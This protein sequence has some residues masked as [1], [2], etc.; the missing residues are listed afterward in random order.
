MAASNNVRK[1]KL[2]T[3]VKC[4]EEY[5]LYLYILIHDGNKTLRSYLSAEP[6]TL[7]E[8]TSNGNPHGNGSVPGKRQP[9]SEKLVI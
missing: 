6:N 3:E 8:E 5:I 2:D 9:P 7:S 4:T 1:T